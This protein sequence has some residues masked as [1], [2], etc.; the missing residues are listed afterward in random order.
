MSDSFLT[1]IS[2]INLF[3]TNDVN[4]FEYLTAKFDSGISTWCRPLP[5]AYGILLSSYEP[6]VVVSADE[7]D[8]CITISDIVFVGPDVANTI[9]AKNTDPA[10]ASACVLA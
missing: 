6:T 4:S 9:P 8:G 10:V 5:P 1:G 3:A 2:G 7:N